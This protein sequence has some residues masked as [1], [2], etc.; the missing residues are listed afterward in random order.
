MSKRYLLVE[1]DGSRKEYSTAPTAD[2]LR[3]REF[4]LVMESEHLNVYRKVKEV[5]KATAVKSKTKHVFLAPKIEPHDLHSQFVKAKKWLQKG[6]KVL[7]TLGPRKRRKLRFITHEELA[8]RV[9]QLE[10]AVKNYFIGDK[11]TRTRV[12]PTE[13]IVSSRQVTAPGSAGADEPRPEGPE[14]ERVPLA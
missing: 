13:Y 14:G 9:G 7:F 3:E 4:Q 10:G 2:F 6:D 5:G 8:V 11:V 1:Q 12:N